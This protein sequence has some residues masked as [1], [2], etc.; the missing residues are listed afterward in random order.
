MDT[1]MRAAVVAAAVGGVCLGTAA[2]AQETLARHVISGGAT[3]PIAESDGAR[4]PRGLVAIYNNIQWDAPME[5]YDFS[6]G[7]TVEGDTAGERIWLA[8]PF[9]PKRNL[10]VHEID[11]AVNHDYGPVG[12][13]L[14][15]ATDFGG[16][17]GDTLWTQRVNKMP[18]FGTCCRLTRAYESTGTPVMAGQTYW[19]TVTTRARQTGEGAAWC[20]NEVDTRNPMA[21]AWDLGGGWIQTTE[22]FPAPAFAVFGS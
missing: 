20:F 14:G 16:I 17:P 21:G 2:G 11:V 8:V 7:Y 5:R 18:E 10:V 9:T 6:N 22:F 15:L 4:P 12:F 1:G 19:I 13:V 3:S